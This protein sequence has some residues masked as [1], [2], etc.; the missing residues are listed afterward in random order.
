MYNCAQDFPL[1]GTSMKQ[2]F[3]RDDQMYDNMRI[4]YDVLLF[5]FSILGQFMASQ[6]LL[7][8]V[9]C[10]LIM[11]FSDCFELLAQRSALLRSSSF[12]HEIL[13]LDL[14][15][16]IALYVK[17]HE[18]ATVELRYSLMDYLSIVI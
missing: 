4:F 14:N 5:Y 3:L 8:N 13:S 1:A 6:L 9:K 17:Q 12:A 10:N 11:T 16:A 15:H 18:E 2:I 7:H